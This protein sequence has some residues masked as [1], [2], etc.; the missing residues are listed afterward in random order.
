MTR[1]PRAVWLAVAAGLVLRLA[2]GFGYWVGK[3]LT[4]D[5]REYL[6]LAE[7]LSEGRGF[8]YGP[9]HDSGTAQQLPAGGNG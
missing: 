4:H 2:F 5:E 3:P 1:T 8:T 6:A 7:S 9:G